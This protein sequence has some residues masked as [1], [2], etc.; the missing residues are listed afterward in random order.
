MNF[1]NYLSSL[2]FVR[3]GGTTIRT[4]ARL[5][6]GAL[7]PLIYASGGA[8]IDADVTT[9]DAFGRFCA[10]Q[11][12]AHLDRANRVQK[13]KLRRALSYYQEFLRTFPSPSKV[14]SNG[15]QR[16]GMGRTQGRVQ[17]LRIQASHGNHVYPVALFALVRLVPRNPWVVAAVL[18][19]ANG[20]CEACKA[21][22]PFVR[23]DGRPYLEVHHVTPLSA[24]G[25]DTVANARALCPTC[26]REQH[27]ALMPRAI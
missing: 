1:Q 8:L 19:R 25:Q 3:L 12:L 21:P 11:G 14:A 18:M 6:E 24:G 5:V 22:A 15:G 20:V 9:D 16:P 27:Y 4:Y 10:R 13:S 7:Q 26:H 2:L 17:P 23:K